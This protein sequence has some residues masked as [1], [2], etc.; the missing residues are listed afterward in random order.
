MAIWIIVT[1]LLT[2]W[3]WSLPIPKDLFRVNFQEDVQ[4]SRQNVIWKRGKVAPSDLT[5]YF[6]NWPRE[7]VNQRLS[8]VLENLDIGNYF[9]AGHPRERVGVEER[10]KFFFFQFL[11]LI[12]GFTSP[13]LNKY[14]KFLVFYSGLA[15]LAVFIFKWRSFEQTLPLAPPFIVLMALGGRQIITWQKKWR[16]L[17]ISL[18]FLEVLAFGFF[19]FKGILR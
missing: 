13:H 14:K 17:F 6:V 19:Y 10:Q 11:L 12:I 4:E 7:V 16:I 5:V 9:F 3:L 18:A 2:P 8:A 1:L 15:L